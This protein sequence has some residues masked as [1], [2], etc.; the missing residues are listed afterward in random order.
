MPERTRVKIRIVQQVKVMEPSR[1]QVHD[2]LVAAGLSLPRPKTLPLLPSISD[3]QRARL[4]LLFATGG[5]L[6][7]LVIAEREER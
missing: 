2:V 3:E 6:S 4:A 1:Q 7:D 5:P